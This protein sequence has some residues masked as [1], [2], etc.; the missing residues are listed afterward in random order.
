M[1]LLFSIAWVLFFIWI[2]THMGKI[3]GKICNKYGWFIA[4]SALI[5][6][7]IF[8]FVMYFIGMGAISIYIP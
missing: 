3:A 6:L 5:I 4:L 1:K 2:G 7:E 8:W